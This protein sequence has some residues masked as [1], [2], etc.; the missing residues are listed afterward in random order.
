MIHI[1]EESRN[2]CYC[3]S[4]VLHTNLRLHSSKTHPLKGLGGFFPARTMNGC[5]LFSVLV[6]TGMLEQPLCCI[7]KNDGATMSI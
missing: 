7:Y 6:S 3:M 5:F 2:N 1:S 4:S